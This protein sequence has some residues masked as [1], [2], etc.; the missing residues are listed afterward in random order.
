MCCIVITDIS[1]VLTFRCDIV[2]EII[3]QNLFT[4]CFKEGVA[5]LS[6]APASTILTSVSIVK[7][8]TPEHVQVVV[9]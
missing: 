9:S 5:C 2:G 4:S 1:D 8:Q 7:P 3:L 6:T